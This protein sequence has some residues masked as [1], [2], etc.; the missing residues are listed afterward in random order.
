MTRFSANFA[1]PRADTDWLMFVVFDVSGAT[2]TCHITADGPIVTSQDVFD[3]ESF[4]RTHS[5][6]PNALVTDWKV[7]ARPADH[8][9]IKWHTDD[10]AAVDLG[11]RGMSL[12]YEELGTAGLKTVTEVITMLADRFGF[13][14]VTEGNP[15]V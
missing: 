5:G 10:I 3:M 12:T 14:V 2:G 1:A 9:T 7:L 15:G 6:L 8:V 11:D 4:V 13:T